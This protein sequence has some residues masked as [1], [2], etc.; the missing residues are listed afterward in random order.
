MY[1]IHLALKTARNHI[2][3]PKVIWDEAALPILSAWH[4]D[5]FIAAA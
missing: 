4:T 1:A 5:P 3:N 2:E